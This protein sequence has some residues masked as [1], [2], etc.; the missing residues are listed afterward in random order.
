[1]K[2]LQYNRDYRKSWVIVDL[3]MEQ[4]PRSTERVSIE[5][6]DLYVR[7]QLWQK[8]TL[9]QQMSSVLLRVSNLSCRAGTYGINRMS[10]IV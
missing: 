7:S 8:Y 10:R 1:M 6:S 4:I 5:T 2:N 3:T 9:K